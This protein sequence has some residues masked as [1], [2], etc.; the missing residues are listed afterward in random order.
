MKDPK[1]KTK[2]DAEDSATEANTTIRNVKKVWHQAREDAQNSD[3]ETDKK[4]TKGW[5]R[6]TDKQE[7]EE[8]DNE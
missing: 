3:N 2:W 1:K 5:K 4:L 6:K 7:K 8:S